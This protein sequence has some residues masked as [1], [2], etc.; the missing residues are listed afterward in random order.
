[1]SLSRTNMYQK[2]RRILLT[3]L[4]YLEVKKLSPVP[5]DLRGRMKPPETGL[6]I[7]ST[8]SGSPSALIRGAYLHSKYDPQKEARRIINRGA[9]PETSTGIFYGFGLGYLVEAFLAGF[10]DAPAA[11]IEPDLDLFLGALQSRD[12]GGL[13][14]SPLVNWFLE[15]EPESII[16]S[17]ETMPLSRP[18]VFRL[19]PLVACQAGYYQ[20][21]DRLLRTALDRKEVNINTLRRFGK[22]WVQ[23]L[24]SNLE[25]FI[26]S[27]G[28]SELAGIFKGFPA[29][30]LAAGP[31][32]D[33]I[34]P[35]L[36][37]LK[38]RLVLVAV[39][40]SFRLCC[41]NGV[42]PDFLVTIDP[43]YW[44]T[45]HLDWAHPKQSV[46]I[47]E[48][49]TN[50]RILRTLSLATY[51]VSSFFPL[52]Q[53]LESIIGRKGTIGAGGSVA[54]T[55]WDFARIMGASPIY[56]AGLDLSFPGKKT[57]A[58]GTFFEESMHIHSNLLSPVEDRIVHYLHEAQLFPVTANS[59]D[60]TLTDRR[61]IIYKWWFENQMQSAGTE[62]S[63]TVMTY[64]LASGGIKIEGMPFID[65]E[66]LLDL[67]LNREKIEDFMRQARH[68]QVASGDK[69]EKR[70]KVILSLAAL[71]E[72]LKQLEKIAGEGLELCR[73]LPPPASMDKKHLDRIL[74]TLD[75]LDKKILDL[76][77]RQVAGFL[78]QGLIRKIIDAGAR[79]LR[80]DETRANKRLEDVF[81]TTEAIYKEL[82][83]SAR[84]HLDLLNRIPAALISLKL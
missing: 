52:G 83:E 12:L 71:A 37:E 80:S 45:R 24:L 74:K 23:N 20:K 84:F 40:T 1:M 32:L 41:L 53:F 47:T 67:P 57:H 82:L 27:P 26:F 68:T 16:M 19:R 5:P 38:D 43:Q 22:L 76:S 3:K 17:I 18:E 64:N 39:D 35:L 25:P 44:N 66:L 51:F 28:I 78:I 56:M 14:S 77:S 60:L 29:L 70:K 42:E 30:V 58:R 10:P 81:E 4:P 49:S 31:S 21:V 48:S 33:Q 9:S 36:P 55:A 72:E 54:T 73:N 79:P 59:G 34:L 65:P 50:P 7:V 6:E 2:N 11:V 8:P 63:S 15:E 69:E 62:I 75:R 61:M 13:F 46:L